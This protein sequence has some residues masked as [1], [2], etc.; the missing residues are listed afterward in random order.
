MDSMATD[1]RMRSTLPLCHTSGLS[2]AGLM[3]WTFQKSIKVEKLVIK[4][5][6]IGIPNKAVT[7]S[8]A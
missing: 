5:S 3:A 7:H 2:Q 8:K 6:T 4:K 1:P